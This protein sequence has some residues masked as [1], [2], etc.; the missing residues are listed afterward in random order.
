MTEFI[1]VICYLSVSG[2]GLQEN[3]KTKEARRGGDCFNL[4]PNLANKHWVNIEIF[5]VKLN[6]LVTSIK[7]AFMKLILKK[8]HI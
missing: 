8:K 4:T 1:P 3:W 7:Y 2:T 5:E 6:I